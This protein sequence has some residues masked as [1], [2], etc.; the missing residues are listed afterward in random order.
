MAERITACDQ[1]MERET[2]QVLYFL[3]ISQVLCVPA[4]CDTA[5][6]KVKIHLRPYPLQHVTIDLWN[7]SDD[8]SLELRQILW[9][10]RQ[11]AEPLTYRMELGQAILVASEAAPGLPQSCVRPSAGANA[12]WGSRKRVSGKVAELHLAGKWCHHCHLQPSTTIPSS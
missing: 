7:G 1:Q 2:L 9:Y 6:V 8:S 3:H 5:D 10:W 12:D 11:K 4:F